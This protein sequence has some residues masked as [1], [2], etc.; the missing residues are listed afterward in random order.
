MSDLL[1]EILTEELPAR[2]ITEAQTQMAD[3]VALHLSELSIE[4]GDVHSFST[5]RRLVVL[6]Q[7]VKEQTQ[8]R[9][10]D[11]KGPDASI[12]YELSRKVPT[13]ALEGFCRG[14]GV[15]IADIRVEGQEGKQY[16]YA[17][18]TVP[19]RQTSEL[20]ESFLSHLPR[21]ITFPKTMRWEESG[22]QF[23]RPIRGLTALFGT[24]V[25]R[26][27]IADVQSSNTT[28]GLRIGKPKALV[29]SSPQ[30]YMKKLREAFVII[31]PTERR[32]SIEKQ[33]EK[34]LK[35]LDA[36]LASDSSVLLDEVV[37]L[38]EYPSVFLGN[39]PDIAVE[40]PESVVRSVLQQQMHSFLV[41]DQHEN[42]L[43]YFLGVR[44][45]L[46]DFYRHRAKG[47]RE[48]GKS[49]PHGCILLH[50]RRH[51]SATGGI[52]ESI[53]HTHLHGCTWHH[54]GQNT[55][56]RAIVSCGQYIHSRD[57]RGTCH[58]HVCCALIQGRPCYKYGEGVYLTPGR[59]RQ[60]LSPP[61][62]RS[63]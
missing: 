39:L 32:R 57:P 47:E 1:I 30:D 45:G 7:A 34:I 20:I 51:A 10:L 11:V 58:A 56:S 48:C 61:S 2:F 63:S 44:N 12:S 6:I 23:A 21:E 36:K 15:S 33:S 35:P 9:I 54:G 22:F 18:K 16:V 60:Y 53:G 27:E 37:N 50:A 31:D 40:L 55:A 13:P 28:F 3:R 4:H 19:G 46:T 62:Q 59:N 49:T 25:L 24:E 43:P 52:R 17:R 26:W 42:V 38:I 41:Y 14:Q 29:V 5:P 8:S